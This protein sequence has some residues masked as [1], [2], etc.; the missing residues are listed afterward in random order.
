M[1]IETEIDAEL[2]AAEIHRRVFAAGGPAVF[3]AHV[4][5]CRFPMVSNLF[6]TME[7]A[8]YIFRDTLEAVRR[9][10]ELKI[11][12][13]AALTRPGGMFKAAADGADHAAASA[14]RRRPCLHTRR[15]SPNCRS[16]SAGRTTAGRS[17]RCRWSTPRTPISRAGDIR[18]SAC[19][20]C[21]SP[22]ASMPPNEE[23]GLHYQI[24]RGIGVHHAAA[25]RRG[26]PLRVNIFVGGA[27]AMMRGRR[28]AAAG[29]NERAGVRRGARPAI[30]SRLVH[31]RCAAADLCR[32][33]FLHHRHDR[34]A[35]RTLPEG[36]FGDHLGYYSLAHEFPVLRVE[37]VYHR[38]GAI[39]PFT[40][41]GRPPQEDTMFGQL[42]HE[43]TGPV[44]PTV[45]P[46]V[47]RCTRSMRR[48]C[49]RCCWRSA[50]SGTCRMP[51]ARGRRNC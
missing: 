31:D 11:D 45:I 24:H 33:R 48:A 39:W 28:D 44:I 3:F 36:P 2:E 8:R 9:L 27:P 1:R 12:P 34:S 5:G 20:A 10:V 35:H 51:S 22:A 21:S 17:S 41:V 49:I 15:R 26:E 37:H 18:T 43:L 46:G 6:G 25:I 40:V 47:K 13:A 32:C 16:C 19:T 42:I 7:R 38:D 4:K 14:Y 30:A 23:V 29:G 50:A